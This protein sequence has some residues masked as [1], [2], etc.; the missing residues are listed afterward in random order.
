MINRVQL[1]LKLAGHLDINEFRKLI[2]PAVSYG[3]TVLNMS[4]DEFENLIKEIKEYLKEKGQF[5]DP[6]N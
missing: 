4:D 5:P 3:L 2:N 6:K 1:I